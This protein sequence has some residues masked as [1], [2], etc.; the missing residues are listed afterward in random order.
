MVIQCP[1]VSSVEEGPYSGEVACEAK[2]VDKDVKSVQAPI[3]SVV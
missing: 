3:S 2:Q 1:T